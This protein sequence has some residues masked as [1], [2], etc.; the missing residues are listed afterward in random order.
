MAECSL[1]RKLPSP[2]QT[3]ECKQLG[4]PSKVGT[5][6]D[7]FADLPHTDAPSD[8]EVRYRSNGMPYRDPW[9]A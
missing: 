7:S 1:C 2:T 5:V 6:F 9:E 8:R 3:R 4:C